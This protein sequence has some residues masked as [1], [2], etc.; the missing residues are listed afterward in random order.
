MS[1]IDST[2]N[3]WGI[4]QAKARRPVSLSVLVLHVRRNPPLIEVSLYL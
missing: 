1:V 4:K 3:Q 2:N